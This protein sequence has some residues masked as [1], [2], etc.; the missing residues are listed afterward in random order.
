MSL[1]VTDRYQMAA[2]TRMI[3]TT[4]TGPCPM[5]SPPDAYGMPKKSANDAPIGRVRM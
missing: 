4:L 3:V 1:C 5:P 2:T